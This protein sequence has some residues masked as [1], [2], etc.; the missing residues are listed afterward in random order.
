MPE[1]TSATDRYLAE[2]ERLLDLQGGE[3]RRALAVA[4]RRLLLIEAEERN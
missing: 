4:R 3:R 1:E 2:I